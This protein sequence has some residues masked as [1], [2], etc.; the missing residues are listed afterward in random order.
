MHVLV[1]GGGVIGASIAFF[2]SERGIRVTVAE[3]TGVA[4]AASGKS[5]GFLARDWCEGSP[6]APLARRSFDLHAELAERLNEDWGYRRMD[7]FGGHAGFTRRREGPRPVGWLS[8]EVSIGQKLGTT[9]TTAQVVPAAFTRAMMRGA[10]A[11]GATLRH[12]RVTGIAAGGAEIDGEPLAAD[13]VVVAMGPWSIL[14][15]QWLNV[16]PV[17]GLKGH[18]LVFDTGSDVP[19]EAVFLEM[20]EENGAQS[21]PEIFPRPDG[22]TYVCAISSEVPLPVDPARV[23]P[24]PGAIERL[25]EMCRSL[26]PVLARAPILARQACCRPVTQDGLPLIGRVDG[27]PGSYIATGHSVWGI[28]N[29]PATGEAMAELIVDGAASSVDLSPF[30][31]N[32]LEPL[33]PKRLFGG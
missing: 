32:R 2:L 12:G 25:E 15:A 10:E 31:P 22:T 23:T 7:T 6:L 18:S 20:R 29:A 13:A 28:L 11:N 4:N 9:A 17:F 14:A 3:S 24:E 16:P 21:S 27:A 26:S 5:G 33:D 1:C 8:G 30:D 19:S